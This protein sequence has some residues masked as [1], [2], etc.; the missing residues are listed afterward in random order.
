MGESGHIN[1]FQTHAIE[2]RFSTIEVEGR[3]LSG[4]GIR[5][6]E[7]ARMPF[8]KERFLPGAFGDVSGLDV[9][10]NVQHNRDRVIARTPATLQ[11]I[12]GPDALRVLATLPETREASDALTNVRAGVLRGLSLEFRAGD[13]PFIDGVRTVRR[14]GLLAFG[15]VD[16]PAYDGS[17]VEARAFEIRQDGDGIQGR[18]FYDRDTVI[19]DREKHEG[20]VE[21]RQRSTR[22]RR[23]APRAFEFAIGAPDREIQLL[24]GRGSGDNVIASKLAGSLLLDDTPTSL[25]FRTERLPDTTAARDLRAIL[26]SDAASPGVEPLYHL[27]P[28]DAVLEPVEVIPEV[29]NEGVD[30]EIV[31]DAVL[32]G[33]A[34]VF[35]APRG[36]PGEVSR[37]RRVWL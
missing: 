26:S 4:V 35:R 33:L 21:T 28:P 32:Y 24:A 17:I 23:Y 10:L 37:R 34:I 13:A 5:Y 2:R 8:G 11:L 30:I 15:L 19:S 25:N 18:I 22:K 31:R 9:R 6:G 29:G 1:E 27:P 36:N 14:A 7:V 16:T 12:D 3:C 20:A